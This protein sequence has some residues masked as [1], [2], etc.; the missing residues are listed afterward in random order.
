MS[1]SHGTAV[2]GHPETGT[3]F[4]SAVAGRAATRCIR[5]S[6]GG[7]VAVVRGVRGLLRD[8]EL[9]APGLLWLL[10]THGL[11]LVDVD[12]DVV[13]ET[14]R[15]RLAP[16]PARLTR[17]DR[18]HL[19]VSWRPGSTA[20]IVSIGQARVVDRV[21]MPTVDH[22]VR[23]EPPVL[24][25]FERGVA[26]TLGPSWRRIGPDRPVPTGIALS[27]GDHIALVRG[28]PLPIA[29]GSSITATRSLGVVALLTEQ[30]ERVA[31]RAVEGIERLDDHVDG[32]RLVG[33]TADAVVVLETPTLEEVGRTDALGWRPAVA[34]IGP[35]RGLAVVE[36]GSLAPRLFVIDWT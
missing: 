23:S 8:G 1:L 4:F 34:A 21:R 25:S 30:L 29:P 16:Y 9:E 7:D 17:L 20:A 35:D 12:R 13:I 27:A 32:T 28:D 15:D 2:V 10:A 24:C 33:V 19:I 3:A 26:R 31:E 11:H 6:G 5:V 14:V 18:D 36:D 22:V